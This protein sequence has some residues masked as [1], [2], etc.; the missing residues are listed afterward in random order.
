[1]T[2]PA[3]PD[4][5]GG[6]WPWAPGRARAEESARSSGNAVALV[7]RGPAA[8]D[9]CAESAAEL[10]SGTRWGFDIRFVGKKEK[11][12]PE[13]D[14]LTTAA[15]YV[16]PGGDGSLRRAYRTMK[17]SGDAIRAY[18]WAGGRYLGLCMGGYLAGHDPGFQLLPLDTEQFI[19]SPGA[20]VR[21]PEDTVVDVD[22]RGGR[23]TVFFQDGPIFHAPAD[24][25]GTTVLA[26][27]SSNGHIAAMVSSFGLG[28]VGVCG[29]H[30][31]A[32]PQWSRD[33]PRRP[34]ARAVELGHDLV[35]LLMSP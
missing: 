16:Q 12:K 14:T 15:L 23:H 26:R 5:R 18:V 21:T 4:G 9:D 11:L 27:Y 35:D 30:P 10:L 19:T 22:W 31:E 1:M 34:D 3:R 13:Y 2:G 17:G 7:Y 24:A 8:C 6:W 29:P 33:L 20:E 25:E 32:P 28:R